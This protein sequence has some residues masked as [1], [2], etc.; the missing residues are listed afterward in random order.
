MNIIKAKQRGYL[1]L[2]AVIIIT[3]VAFFASTIMY[4]YLATSESGAKN[5]SAERAYYVAQS[6]MERAI[7]GYL[8]EN[9]SCT[10]INATNATY[11]N[12]P[13]VDGQFSV[14][15]SASTAS[16]TLSA[17]INASATTIPVTSTVGFSLNTGVATID[18]EII[19]YSGVSA[20]SLFGVVRGTNGTTAAIHAINATVAQNNCVLTAVGTVSGINGSS[21][22][23]IQRALSKGSGDNIA[24]GNNGFIIRG[25][26]P[27]WTTLASGT[28][29]NL[30]DIV[31]RT[32]TDGWVVGDAIGGQSTILRWNGDS[33][34][35]VANP[36]TTNLRGVLAVSATEAWAVGDNNLV[37]K[38]NGTQWNTVTV[39]AGTSNLY[40]VSIID[41]NG[42][43]IGDFGFVVGT[44]GRMIKY[45]NGVWADD[46]SRTTQNLLKAWT[47]SRNGL[48]AAFAFGEYVRLRWR[49]NP[50]PDRWFPKNDPG[51]ILQAMV[52]GDNNPAD[53][54]ADFVYIA[55]NDGTLLSWKVGT[56]AWEDLT[57]TGANIRGLAALSATQVLAVGSIGGVHRVM[58]W[59]G[60]N[61]WVE[62][63]YTTN[64]QL[65]A[66]AFVSAT[67][68]QGGLG[69][70]SRVYN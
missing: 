58:S 22:V 20:N 50:G 29:A 53:G 10:Q 30:N 47:V 4:M 46:D 61:A 43:G 55:G 39:P 5:I 23:I 26:G 44:G 32:P 35:A 9:T 37:L 69:L 13:F 6:G 54:I 2:T 56:A 21:S 64:T 38:W 11:T 68:A 27:S 34:S 16:T 15:G 8:T 42:D 51:I 31:I 33:F 19:Q 28:V 60:V 45:D 7:Y 1:I 65:N 57:N 48:N 67:T 25:S 62:S 17:G 18:Q 40:G 12:V 24:V 66:I 63:G 59:D 52:A 36:G 3:A 70:W 41:T 49:A 14:V